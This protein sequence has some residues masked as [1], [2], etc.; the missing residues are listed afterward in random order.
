MSATRLQHSHNFPP[1]CIC[2]QVW[3]P[4]ALSNK[5]DSGY[6]PNCL[7]RKVLAHPRVFCSWLWLMGK[8]LRIIVL[9]K[10]RLPQP[11]PSPPN[12]CLCFLCVTV[13]Q[14]HTKT[15]FLSLC[16]RIFCSLLALT[17][18]KARS[19]LFVVQQVKLFFSALKAVIK[20]YRLWSVH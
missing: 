18:Y 16:V 5:L 14:T 9:Q 6:F 13:G 3:A 2:W 7:L 15:L 4:L 1:F 8:L 20:C 12:C 17:C 19:D 11:M 10:G